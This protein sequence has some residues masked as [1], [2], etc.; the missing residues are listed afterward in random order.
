[1]FVQ[2]HQGQPLLSQNMVAE[3]NQRKY[4]YVKQKFMNIY[5]QYEL[6]PKI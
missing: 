5:E 3:K 6:I 1:M 2:G 4:I